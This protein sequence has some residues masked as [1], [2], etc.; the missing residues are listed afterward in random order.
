MA[1]SQRLITIPRMLFGT[2]CALAVPALL[3][4]AHGTLVVTATVLSVTAA[5]MYYSNA[6]LGGVVGDYIGGWGSESCQSVQR[7]RRI[8]GAMPSAGW[9][10][11]VLVKRTAQSSSASRDAAPPAPGASGPPSFLYNLSPSRRHNPG[12]RDRGLP[13]T[14]RRL[15]RGGARRVAAAGHAVCG[16]AGARRLV[17][18][19]CGLLLGGPSLSLGR[20]RARSKKN[21]P[22]LGR[23]C[24]A[25]LRLLRWRQARSK[26]AARTIGSSATTKIRSV[27]L[28]D[29]NAGS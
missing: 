22:L 16:D 2:A 24:A 4:G 25:I 12:H 28:L 8:L 21:E 5:A 19:H 18:P 20:A 10:C 11:K 26:H 23:R 15:G 27:R 3:L 9:A 1:R 14:R 7:A 6:I 29:V 17:P 13:G